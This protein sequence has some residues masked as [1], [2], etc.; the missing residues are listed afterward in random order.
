MPTKR[1]RKAGSSRIRGSVRKRA[2]GS[3][4][5]GGSLKRKPRK[6]VRRGGSTMMGGS[7]RRRRK[8]GGM[9]LRKKIG[10]GLGVA[11]SAMALG[12]LGK[13]IHSTYQIYK[14]MYDWKNKKTLSWGTPNY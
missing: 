14:P 4:R 2:A 8:G 7:I 11:G 1:K 12:A 10:I 6:R 13:G 3:S 9:S 5:I